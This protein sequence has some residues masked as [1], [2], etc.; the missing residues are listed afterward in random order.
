[1][2]G[3]GTVQKSQP[4]ITRVAVDATEDSHTLR[5]DTRSFTVQCQEFEEIRVA[6]ASGETADSSDYIVLRP[7]CSLTED[8]VYSVGEDWVIYLRAPNVVSAVGVAVLEW[9]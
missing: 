6:F 4:I 7:N 8:D 3:L 2:G 9:K 5:Q 1:M